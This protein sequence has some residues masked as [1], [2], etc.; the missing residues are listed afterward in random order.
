MKGTNHELYAELMKRFDMNI[1]A[2]GGVSSMD[3]VERL[4]GAGLYGAIIGKAYYTKA[5]DL[6]KAV[7]VAE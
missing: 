2:S 1:T 3:D 7:E 5:I 4:A 6:K